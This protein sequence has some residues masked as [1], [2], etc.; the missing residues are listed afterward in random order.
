VGALI[1]AIT[2]AAR[3]SVLGLGRVIPLTASLFGAALIAFAGSRQFWLSLLLLVITGFGFM[4]Q[5]AASNTVLQTIAEDKKRGR[6]M[7]FYSMAFQGMAPFGSL[8]AGAAASRIG[9]PHTLTI[10]GGICLCGAGWFATQL[11]V[12]RALVR[13]IYIQIGVIPE[14]ASGIQTASLLQQKP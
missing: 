10:G 6:V 9:A 1:G 11:P 4:Q 8:I 14:V 7:S 2:L 13:P 12:L 3:Q 5:M